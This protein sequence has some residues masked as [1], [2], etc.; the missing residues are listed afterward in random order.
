MSPA[1]IRE[2]IQH[3]A[4]VTRM[5]HDEHRCAFILPGRVRRFTEQLA[6]AWI[7]GSESSTLVLVGYSETVAVRP[8]T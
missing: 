1:R 7:G 2:P 5:Y 4:Q 6:V 8:A 3:G